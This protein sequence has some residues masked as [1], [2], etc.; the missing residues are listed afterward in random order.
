VHDREEPENRPNRVVV[1]SAREFRQSELAK[2]AQRL[3]VGLSRPGRNVGIPVLSS[4][5]FDRRS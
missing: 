3:V 5:E 2:L 4:C 1:R